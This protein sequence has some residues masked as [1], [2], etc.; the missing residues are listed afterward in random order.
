MALWPTLGIVAGYRHNDANGFRRALQ[1]SRLLTSWEIFLYGVYL[2][3][4]L[5]IQRFDF[6]HH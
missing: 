2:V 1:R 5:I 6:C 4:V 3:H